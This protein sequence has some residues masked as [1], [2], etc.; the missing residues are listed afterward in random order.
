MSPR[1]HHPSP[2]A[3]ASRMRD[4]G[5]GVLALLV[6][7]CSVASAEQAAPATS[8]PYARDVTEFGPYPPTSPIAPP[9]ASF[10]PLAAPAPRPYPPVK[11]AFEPTPPLPACGVFSDC[12]FEN[13]GAGWFS[14]DLTVPLFNLGVYGAGQSPGYGLFTSA[15]TQG[16]KAVLTGWD[17]NGPGDIILFQDV[18]LQPKASRLEFDYRAGW[19]MFNFTGSTQHRL[20][21][22]QIQP[23]GG[24]APLATTLVLLAAAGSMNLDTGNLLG[25]VDVSAHAGK[26]VRVLFIWRVPEFATG[27]AFFQLDNIRVREN[28]CLT[29]NNC[30]FETGDLSNWTAVDL[31][32]PFVPAQVRA[33]GTPMPLLN[34][35][36]SDGTYAFTHGWNGNG[37]GEILL[38]QDVTLPAAASSIAFD[39]RAAWNIGASAGRSFRFEVQP[40]GG[41]AP[42]LSQQILIAAANTNQPDTGPLTGLMSLASFQGLAVRLVFRW[43]VPENL[44]GPANFQLDRIRLTRGYC[45]DIQN[46]S[47]ETGALPAWVGAD[48]ATPFYAMQPGLAG[49]SPGYGLFLS[50]PTEGSYALLLGFDGSGPGVIELRQDVTLPLW[51]DQLRFDYRA[52]WDML[53][54]VGSTKPRIFDVSIEPFGGGPALVKHVVL[55]AAEGTQV[56]DTGPRSKALSVGAYAGQNVRI[57]FRW[58]I[59]E[60]FT[61]PGFFQLDRVM[62]DDVVLA[63]GPG[64]LAQRLELQPARPNPSRESASFAFTLPHTGDVELEIVDVRGARVW[65]ERHEALP[66]GE[67]RLGWGG[68][69]TQGGVAP[70]GVYYARVRTQEGST[71]RMFV[72]VR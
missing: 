59:P 49:V 21:S 5:A 55:E 53:T 18:I 35:L 10:P 40:S 44:S 47:F 51:G 19:D 65:S 14:Y 31:T 39:Y 11:G 24:G 60:Y 26:S 70:A 1:S 34:C 50:A 23:S 36:P 4:A 62:I 57:A 37:P 8:A 45:A 33:A 42:L 61:G 3:G 72:R 20:F 6:T 12:S 48:L 46:C 71:S 28:T 15:P 30:S 9:Y 2:L 29:V 38:Y 27:P 32:V 52:G 58:R 13:N 63:V 69:T 56:L 41:G 67:H 68:R 66:A 7:L 43:T 22:V 54:F 64:A 25:S 16:T 17:G